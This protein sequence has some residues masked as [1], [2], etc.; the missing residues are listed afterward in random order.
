MI[1][2]GLKAIGLCLLFTAILLLVYG[3]TLVGIAKMLGRLFNA[4]T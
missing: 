1:I 2:F 3:A 4:G